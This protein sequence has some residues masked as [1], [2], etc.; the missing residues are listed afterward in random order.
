VRWHLRSGY[1]DIDLVAPRLRA[2]RDG[3][4]GQTNPT[5]RTPFESRLVEPLQAR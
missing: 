1:G 2:L 5:P 4:T 3:A